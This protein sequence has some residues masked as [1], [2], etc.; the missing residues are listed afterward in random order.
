MT[1]KE[2][3]QG[4]IKKTVDKIKDEE[5]LRILFS[6]SNKMHKKEESK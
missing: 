6:L 4:E 1:E 5:F 2:F 3:L